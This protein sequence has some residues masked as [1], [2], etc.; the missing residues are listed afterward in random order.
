MMLIPDY[1]AA[2]AAPSSEQIASSYRD[3]TEEV[4]WVVEASCRL[5]PSAMHEMGRRKFIRT[6]TLAANLDVKTYDAGT[7]FVGTTDGSATNWGKLWL[8]YDV[9]LFVPQLPPAGISGDEVI[10]GQTA[11]SNTQIFGTA[12]VTTGSVVLAT[13]AVNTVTILNPGSYFLSLRVAGTGT[14]VVSVSGTAPAAGGIGPTQSGT[15]G[16]GYTASFTT[17]APNQTVVYTV[18]NVVTSANLV[19]SQ[20]T[21]AQAMAV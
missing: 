16:A 4:P 10:S 15:T 18:T 11:I 6:G 17:T 7:F 12:P 1:D 19:I 2:D 20:M 21:A 8:E 5:D 14:P 3:V 9:E 13:A